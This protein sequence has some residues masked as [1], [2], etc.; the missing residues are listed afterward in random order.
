M[1]P[2]PVPCS[3]YGL[4]EDRTVLMGFTDGYNGPTG[5]QGTLVVK[6]TPPKMP[7]SPSRLCL[8]LCFFTW[9]C[10]GQEFLDGIS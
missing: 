4:M 8:S 2:N 10:R 9:S 1:P 5:S 7:P 6:V 3:P